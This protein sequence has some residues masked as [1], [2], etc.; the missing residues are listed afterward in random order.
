[1]LRTAV[2]TI[3]LF[4]CRAADIGDRVQHCARA[5]D[6][7]LLVKEA[8]IAGGS[9]SSILV[10]PKNGVDKRDFDDEEQALLL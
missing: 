7:E 8:C 3:S 9:S 2:P 10:E 5:C 4:L 6:V 1:M